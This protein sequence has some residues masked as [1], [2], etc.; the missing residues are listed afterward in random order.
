MLI[1][2]KSFIFI[3]SNL[4]A[5]GLAAFAQLYVIFVVTK[6]QSQDDSALLFLLLGYGI[7]F[8]MFEFGLAQ[9]LQNKF[10]S[11]N[12]YS[13]DVLKTILLHYIFL[14]CVA[15]FIVF[16]PYLTDLLLAKSKRIADEMAIHSFSIGAAILVLASSNALTQR[17]LL[18]IDKGLLGNLLL[19]CQS[20]ISIIGLTIFW[21]YGHPSLM[22]AVIIYLGPQV[23]VF[24]PV[25]IGFAYKLKNVSIKKP[26]TLISKIFYDS[27]GFCGIG[28]MS[29]VFLG[30]DYFFASHFLESSEVISY[31][32]V[33]RIFFISFVIYYA[34]LLH[35]VKRL[36]RLDLMRN[37]SGVLSTIKDSVFLGAISVFIIYIFAVILE[38]L[39]ILGYMTNGLGASQFLLFCGF[40]YFLTRVLR[41]VVVVVISSLNDK[42]LLYKVYLIE[43]LT[44]IFFMYFSAP[45]YG[46]IGIFISM[47]GACFFGLLY[48]FNSSRKSIFWA[49]NL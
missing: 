33:T 37:P 18:I 31:Y 24:I 12:I 6:M 25:L 47:T 32:L 40:L 49:G 34:H 10:N 4:C 20:S 17:F 16:T 29:A 46:G 7:W 23:L 2:K 15:S 14:L 39:G 26:N 36:S 28:V 43:I 8:Q 45:S 13:R 38:S 9:T 22:I 3:F 48:V 11:K 27:L 1:N 5:K 41:D 30:S 19:V 35:R 44:A 42:I 21:F